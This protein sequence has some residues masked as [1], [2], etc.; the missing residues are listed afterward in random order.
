MKKTTLIISFMI[1]SL[2]VSTAY[3]DAIT[4]KDKRKIKLTP[5]SLNLHF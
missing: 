1:L 5:L 3:A 4:V 2:G